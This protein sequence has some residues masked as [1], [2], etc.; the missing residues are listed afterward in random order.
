MKMNK[1]ALALA[2]ASSVGVVSNAQAVINLSATSPAPVKIANEISL[3]NGGVFYNKA[4]ASTDTTTGRLV[5]ALPA[6][7][8][9]TTNSNNKYFVKV[10]LLDGATFAGV[11]QL[12]CNVISDA[13]ATTAE[14]E[15]SEMISEAAG[16]AGA[17]ATTDNAT[18]A[19]TAAKIATAAA[20]PAGSSVAATAAAAAKEVVD[21]AIDA[22]VA[23][24]VA[25]GAA[26]GVAPNDKASVA[27]AINAA[28]VAT[29]AN[30]AAKAAVGK[31]QLKITQNGTK[32]SSLATF[33]LNDD[34]TMKSGSCALSIFNNAQAA[35][36]PAV[37][38]TAYYN[39]TDKQD[40]RMSA[41]VEF[42]DGLSNEST[43]V[44]A[45]FI[46]FVTG[47][48][49]SANTR[50][51]VTTTS[52]K[53]NAKGQ[54]SVQDSSLKFSDGTNF[55]QTTAFVGSVSYNAADETVNTYGLTSL[56]V[57]K[58]EDVLTSAAITVT[59]PTLGGVDS[60]FLA[61]GAATNPC[62]G[63]NKGTISPSGNTS[64]TFK[65]VKPADLA[66]GMNICIAVDGTTSIPAGQFTVSVTGEA[67]DSAALDF[68]AEVK[69]FNL[70]K[71]GSAHRV[72]NIPPAGVAD[73]AFIR[74]YNVSSFPGTVLG[75]MRDSAGALIGSQ[76]TVVTT[77]NAREV[78][79]INADTLKTLF[80]DWTG[81]SRLF[82]EA[83]IDDLR[84]QSL[85][86]S[87]DVLE[88]MS[89]RAE[90]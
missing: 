38:M 49:V 87:S 46:D 76:G 75:E 77:L 14:T 58:P 64:V 29:N 70:E 9:Y 15:V 12:N 44:N 54:I 52:E 26:A 48:S 36:D 16:A 34:E 50:A 66:E 45:V 59:S 25:D 85:M 42:Q 74:I 63:D 90:D 5:V 18:A 20:V 6:I 39:L 65:S 47:F 56:D 3:Q 55:S 23:A 37:G 79:V 40:Q 43:G 51:L 60:V 82:L 28:A 19:A 2:I 69:L 89:G 27:D 13:D 72:L 35:G 10:S 68:G 71:N 31:T 84:V 62:A 86:R 21:A 80:G 17:A 57:A 81:R 67:L 41:V 7:K 32:G 4:T 83:D 88:N 53:T 1:T 8:G 11:P 61:M 33:S 78:K 22:A 30:T 73:K 24:A